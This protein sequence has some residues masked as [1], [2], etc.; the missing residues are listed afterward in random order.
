MPTRFTNEFEM[1]WGFPFMDGNLKSPWSEDMQIL[2][3]SLY[4]VDN[5]GPDSVG[6]GGK[7]MFAPMASEL[8]C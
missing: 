1:A 8:N 7:P 4:V 5:N 2:F 6:G 3:T